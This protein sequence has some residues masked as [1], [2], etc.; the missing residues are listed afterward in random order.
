[1]VD[2]EKFD[3][4]PGSGRLGSDLTGVGPAAIRRVITVMNYFYNYCNTSERVYFIKFDEEGCSVMKV[5]QFPAWDI[6]I[7]KN[8]DSVI[9]KHRETLKRGLICESQGFGIGA[10]GYYRRIVEL[11]IDELLA[12]ISDLL[13]GDDKA[14]YEDALEL[15]REGRSH[16]ERGKEDSKRD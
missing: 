4:A 8:L 5:G 6:S 16:D 14:R 3:A 11:T 9:S 2:G 13:Q 7:P 1:V 12:S 10:Y 15:I